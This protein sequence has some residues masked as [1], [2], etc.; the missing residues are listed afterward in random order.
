MRIFALAAIFL[1]CGYSQPTMSHE[2]IHVPITQQQENIVKQGVIN[3]LRDPESAKFGS[4][5]AGKDDI[6]RIVVCGYVNARNIF[7]G[8]SGMKL[9]TGIFSHDQTKFIADI[10]DE[11][12]RCRLYGLF[13]QR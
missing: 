5:V 13:P 11:A 10:D 12:G 2:L 1:I 8:Y 7:G 6:D 4:M 9:F 3:D